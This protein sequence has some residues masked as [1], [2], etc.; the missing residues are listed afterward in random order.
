MF[1]AIPWY[2]LDAPWYS[3]DIPWYSLDAPKISIHAPNMCHRYS[4]HIPYAYSMRSHGIPWYSID[5]QRILRGT[6][7][8]IILLRYSMRLHRCSMIFLRYSMTFLG[9]FT[10]FLRYAVTFHRYSSRFLGYAMIFLRCSMTF[11]RYSMI[12][13]S[14]STYCERG[15]RLKLRMQRPDPV[16]PGF[17]KYWWSPRTHSIVSA[18]SQGELASIPCAGPFSGPAPRVQRGAEYSII[19]YRYSMIFLKHSMIWYDI[20]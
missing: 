19:S 4:I 20:I 14:H 1:H 7:Y 2:S 15:G 18:Y 9:S 5:I 16:A 6:I 8:W 10:R 11:H 17:N 3:L 12:C 13:L